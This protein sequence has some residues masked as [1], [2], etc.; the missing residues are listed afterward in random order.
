[1]QGVNGRGQAR[2]PVE[3][4]SWSY[5]LRWEAVSVMGLGGR[6]VPDMS[7]DLHPMRVKATSR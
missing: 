3:I 2:L 6:D 7:C 5:A 4:A 1:M